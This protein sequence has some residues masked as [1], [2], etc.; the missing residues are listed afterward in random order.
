[1][2][3][4]GRPGLHPQVRPLAGLVGVWR[5]RGFGEY[6]SITS[7]EYREEIRFDHSG[8]PLL[9]YAQRTWSADDHAPLHSESG[10]WRVGAGGGVEVVL[11]HPFGVVEISE[12]RVHDDVVEVASRSLVSTST[13]SRVD[14]IRRILRLDGDV[15]S[16]TVDMAASGH[17][18]QQHLR[19]EL[20]RVRD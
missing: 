2:T 13:G 1:V 7:F 12:G 10:F 8:K 18:L 9:F 17:E 3:V 6:P 4:S 16:Y 5:G 19:G 14:G 11:A 20:T 15:L